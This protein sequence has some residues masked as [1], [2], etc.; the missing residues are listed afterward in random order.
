VIIMNRT[1]KGLM[2]LDI[3]EKF[4]KEQKI[5]CVESVYQSDRVIENA[6]EFIEKLCNISGYCQID[7]DGNLIEPEYILVDEDMEPDANGH[8]IGLD[9]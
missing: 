2:L 5:T 8:Y 3:V 7:D 6:Y 1:E 4:I 9:R